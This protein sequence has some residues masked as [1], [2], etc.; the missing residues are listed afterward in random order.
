MEPIVTNTESKQNFWKEL[1]KLVLVAVVI[2][3]PFRLFIAQ[4]FIVDGASMDPTFR[5]SQYLIVDELT[6]HFNTPERG[7]V[8]IFKY[9]KDPK[10]FF[11]KRVIGLPGE[12]VRIINGEVTIVNTE[13]P[14]GLKLVEPYVVY[15]KE[16]SH[17]VKLGEGE[18]FVMGDNRAG[19]SDSR[20]W[21]PVPEKNVV[22]R[23]IFRVWPLSLWPG[24]LEKF[25]NEKN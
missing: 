6:Y 22:G 15:K 8:L 18:Y 25:T 5:N 12:E 21:G 17:S 1:V 23:P 4:P 11:I 2:V 13:N 7:S 19:S 9:P 20:F 14:N 10:K 16:D 3:V 24:S